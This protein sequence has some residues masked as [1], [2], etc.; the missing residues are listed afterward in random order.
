MTI[1]DLEISKNG[2]FNFEENEELEYKQ[3]FQKKQIPS[4]LRIL[5]SMA[6]TR[7]G[8]IMFGIQEVNHH[9]KVNGLKGEE[10]HAFYAF[11]ESFEN[12]FNEEYDG[13]IEPVFDIKEYENKPYAL[14]SVSKSA[15][16]IVRIKDESAII[17]KGDEMISIK[18]I[19]LPEKQKKRINIR[20]QSKFEDI[21]NSDHA[22]LPNYKVHTTLIRKQY[23][24][25]YMSL[26]TFIK[27]IENGT[28]MFQEPTAWEDQYE[29]RFYKANYSK[30]TPLNDP[31]KMFATCT[32]FQEKNEAAWKVYARG[33]T[34]LESRCIQLKLDWALLRKCFSDSASNGKNSDNIKCTVYEGKVSYMLSEEDILKIHKKNSPYHTLFFKPFNME[35]FIG[36]HLFKRPAFA[37]EQEIRFF[38]V[39]NTSIQRI[40]TAKKATK[41]FVKIPWKDIIKEVRID[42]RCSA[43][44]I[45]A[46]QAVCEDNGIELNGGKIVS[47]PSTP[48]GLTQITAV[49]FDIDKMP[50]P[51]QITIE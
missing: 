31:T 19:V 36:L 48:S 37:Y 5:V 26:E 23:I 34:G 3:N 33:N 40:T 29:R 30:L 38:M 17:R 32:T 39:P 25:K 42:K 9:G 27:C 20:K 14:I 41:L 4:Y 24:Y 16:T 7:G 50:G 51:K 10:I 6:N 15:E 43:S 2:F 28:M 11:K 46:L 22:S 13:E 18:K 47:R 8:C 49:E 21:N 1:N 45:L 35:K 44:E 12:W